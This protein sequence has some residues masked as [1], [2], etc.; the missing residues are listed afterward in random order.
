MTVNPDALHLLRRLDLN[1]YE[2]KAFYALSAYGN[3]TAGELSEL[4]DLP[5][6]RVYDVLKRLQDRGFVLIQQGRPVKY[7]AL[8]ITE[9]VKTLRKQREESLAGE[10]TKI[11]E[12]SKDLAAKLKPATSVAK[13]V[14]E[15]VWTL[16]GRDAIFSKMGLMLAAAK[17]H[18]VLASNREGALKKIKTHFKELAKAQERGVKVSIVAPLEPGE[19]SGLP[20]V[21]KQLPSRM[22]LADDQALLFLSEPT[23]KPDEETGVW[24]NSPRVVETLKKLVQNE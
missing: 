4:A 2:A 3:H 8:P 6:P 9:A 12:L 13:A 18:V 5:R 11:D 14:Q 7:S 10:L 16:K 17:K 15:Q 19:A 22:L 24:L 20:L 21:S 23:A 1:Q